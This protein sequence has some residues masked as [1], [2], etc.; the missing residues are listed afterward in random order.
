MDATLPEATLHSLQLYRLENE[1]LSISVL[2]Q[3]GAKIYDLVW[4]STGQQFL[5]HNPRILPQCYPIDSNFDNYWSG[6]W[7]DVYPT[8]DACEYKGDTFPNCGELRSLDWTVERVDYGALELSALGPISPVKARKR[9]ELNGPTVSLSSSLENLGPSPLHFLWGTHPS[10]A[11]RAGDRLRVPAETALVSIASD[12][13][14]GFPGQ[15]YQWPYLDHP[16]GRTD[17]SQVLPIE[18]AVNCGHYITKLRAGWFAV[19][20]AGGD[21]GILFR[22]P[23]E[24]CPYL[25]MWIVYGGWRGY[26][27]VVLEPW[28]GYPVNLAEAARKNRHTTLSP[29]QIFEAR[30]EATIYH[31]PQTLEDV[32]EEK[33]Q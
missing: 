33:V 18:A 10:L 6:G 22:F 32:L 14:L 9:V 28:T 8:A 26:H 24:K 5:W 13:S 1:C 2:P 16:R 12:A 15:E 21:S 20:A 25:W 29:G 27:H 3:V 23:I 31:A 30:I 11:V 7:D 4:K 17:M 19:E